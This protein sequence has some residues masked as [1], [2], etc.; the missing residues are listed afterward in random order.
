MK[1]TK[2]RSNKNEIL[3]GLALY[4]ELPRHYRVKPHH[5]THTSHRQID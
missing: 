3:L 5:F 1:R 4:I 2:A